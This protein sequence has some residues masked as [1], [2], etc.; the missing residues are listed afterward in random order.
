VLYTECLARTC[1]ADLLELYESH[2]GEDVARITL[3][4]QKMVDLGAEL[5]LMVGKT[6]WSRGDNAH[7]LIIE[8]AKKPDLAEGI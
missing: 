8:F 1:L 5:P 4:Y 2:Y 6:L 3:L 7:R